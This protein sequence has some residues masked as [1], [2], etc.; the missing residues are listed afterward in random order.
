[1]DSRDLRR[2]ERCLQ[3][4]VFNEALR[5]TTQAQW[6]FLPDPLLLFVFFFMPPS[7]AY[8][9]SQTRGQLGAAAANLRHSHGN[10]RPEP[11]LQ[12]QLAAMPDP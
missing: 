3:P 7:V 10:A 11:H 12:L 1:M 6:W 2:Q 4:G 8:G 9:G 5:E